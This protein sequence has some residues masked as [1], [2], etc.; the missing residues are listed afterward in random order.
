MFPALPVSDTP[1]QD[2]KGRTGRKGYRLG[3]GYTAVITKV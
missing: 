1:D 2:R 3:L